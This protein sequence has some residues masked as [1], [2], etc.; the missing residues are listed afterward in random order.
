M[1]GMY[2]EM[3]NGKWKMGNKAQTVSFPMGSFSIFHFPFA[4]SHFGFSP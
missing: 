3:E 1:A 4:F 2:T